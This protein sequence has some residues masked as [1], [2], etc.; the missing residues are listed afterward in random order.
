MAEEWFYAKD[1]QEFGPYSSVQMKRLGASGHI[2]PTDLVWK[3]GMAKRV[4]AR[5]VKGLCPEPIRTATPP[6][7]AG[8]RTRTPPPAPPE[9]ELVELLPVDAP[10]T[11]TQAVVSTQVEEFV[12]LIPVE[13][14]PPPAIYA[15]TAPFAQAPPAPPP[16]PPAARPARGI[17]V[18]AVAQPEPYDDESSRPTRPRRR[19]ARG[20]LL[21]L[22]LLLGGIGLALLVGVLVLVLVLTGGNKVTPEN[23]A[24]LRG[25][26][27]ENEVTQILGA[28]TLASTRGLNRIL[29]WQSG[30]NVVTVSFLNDRVVGLHAA[31]GG[32]P[33]GPFP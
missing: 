30:E 17:P 12:E 10:S 29:I 27:T 18:A 24:K 20:S 1:D 14:D 31:F 32:R 33:G 13:P 16:A 21:W 2:Q 25:G 26:M 19:P 22:W 4:P 11:P 6:P 9:E 28:P 8:P 7:P 23:F 5:A 15:P 3:A